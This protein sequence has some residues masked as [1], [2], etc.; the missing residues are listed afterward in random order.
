MWAQ[1][2]ESVKET[3]QAI[4]CCFLS[5]SLCIFA[6]FFCSLFLILGLFTRPAAIVLI[7]NAAVALVMAHNYE[8]FG[9][10][11][12]ITLYLGAYLTLL[13]MGPGKISVDGMIAK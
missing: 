6:E 11:Q 12:T 8:F 5:L 10:G 7:I 1:Q 13:I 3:S 2:E 9:D 4:T